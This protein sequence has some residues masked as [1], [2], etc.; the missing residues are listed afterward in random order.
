MKAIREIYSYTYNFLVL[1][2]STGNNPRKTILTVYLPQTLQTIKCKTKLSS[3]YH[4][5]FR[6]N[7]DS[8]SLDIEN[9][10]KLGKKVCD[11]LGRPYLCVEPREVL[12]HI[13]TFFIDQGKSHQITWPKAIQTVI[14]GYF[15]ASLSSLMKLYLNY[16]ST[17]YFGD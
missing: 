16:H 12:E 9:N 13:P 3:R 8:S 7:L 6:W 10:I 15:L 11:M 4:V 2:V 14:S 1:R 17:I 5:L